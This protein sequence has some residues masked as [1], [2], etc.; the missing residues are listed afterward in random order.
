M[1]RRMILEVPAKEASPPSI[2]VDLEMAAQDCETS[3]KAA[4]T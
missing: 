4:T 2:E 1:M 3:R